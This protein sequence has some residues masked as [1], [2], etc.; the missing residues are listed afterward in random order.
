MTYIQTSLLDAIAEGERL[1]EIGMQSAVDHANAKSPGWSAKAREFIINKF[2]PLH[3]RFMTEDIRAF[4]AL[5]DFELPPHGRAWGGVVAGLAKDLLI[6]NIGTAKVKN[7][8]AHRTPA[9]V[10]ERND[11]RLIQE[12]LWNDQ[13]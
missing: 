7:P 5:H 4:A 9:S 8:K 13:A 10:W 1:K 11:E 12:N 3:K 2:L 6:I